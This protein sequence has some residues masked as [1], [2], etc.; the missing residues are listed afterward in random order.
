MIFLNL[1]YFISKRISNTKADSFSGTIYKIAIASIGIGLAIMIISF[2]I[3][4]GFQEKIQNKMISFEGHL[5][6]TK[7]S[8]SQ[9]FEEEPISNDFNLYR[10]YR[11]VGFIKHLQQFAHKTGLMKA[12]DEVMGVLV[13]GV[14][15]DFDIDRFQQNIIKGRFIHLYD[16]GYSKTGRAG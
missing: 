2:L 4:K 10:N 9:S 8:L 12:N 6:I 13:K 15:T 3:L 5:Q 14:T 7:F 1:S 11:E 16:S